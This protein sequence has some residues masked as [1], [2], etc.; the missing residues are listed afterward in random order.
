MDRVACLLLAPS[1]CLPHP[2][3]CLF[4]MPL[5]CAVGDDETVGLVGTFCGTSGLGH[6]WWRQTLCFF[7]TPHTPTPFPLPTCLFPLPAPLPP[8]P[9][10]HTHT[11][12][13]TCYHT[14][15]LPPF[16]PS[17]VSPSP[18]SVSSAFLKHAVG[19]RNCCTTPTTTACAS[20][21][22]SPLSHHL[23]PVCSLVNIY[24][25]LPYMPM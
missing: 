2:L 14:H 24:H 18:S 5:L 10:P 21:F 3:S 11:Y 4:I 1:S 16:P 17:P 12:P 8:C 20:F 9:L 6:W 7:P 15:P 22:P 23:S 13:H 19:R 25:S